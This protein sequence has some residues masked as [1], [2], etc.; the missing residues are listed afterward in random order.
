MKEKFMKLPN[1]EEWEEIA[2]GFNTR[3][4]FPNCMGALDGKHIRIVNPQG[5]G[6]EYF[7]Y[8]QFFSVVL[9]A[10]VDSNYCFTAIDIGSYGKNSDSNIFRQSALHNL[11]VKGKLSIPNDQRLPDSEDDTPM[12]F[13]IVADEAFSMTQHVLRPYAKRN[14]TTQKIL[15]NY[16]L[17]RARRFVECTFG[18][19]A[20]KWRVFHGAICLDSEFVVEVVQA[21]CDLH[22]FVRVRDGFQFEDTLSCPLEDIPV[23]GTGGAPLTAKAIRDRFANYFTSPAGSVPWQFDMI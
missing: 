16:R 4:N 13:V 6:S 1:T 9:L 11:L 23:L 14:L 12:P 19:L 20:N 10:L 21:A 2:N 22:N 18:L 5:S 15:F 8:K 3:A 7:N 17:S